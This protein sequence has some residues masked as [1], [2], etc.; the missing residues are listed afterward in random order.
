MPE[1][2]TTDLYV[3]ETV[4]DT[5]A[6]Q[7]LELDFLLPD[8]EPEVFRV[9]KTRVSP[10]VQQVRASGGRLEIS[11]S[12]TVSVLYLG[13]DTHTLHAV[14]QSVPFSKSLDL[15]EGEITARC[16]PRCYHVNARAVSG[17]RLEVR[18]GL[19][20][21]V[22][23]MRQVP[24]PVLTDAAGDGVQLHRKEVTCCGKRVTA[25]K[26]CTLSEDLQLGDAKPAFGSLLDACYQVSITETKL[27]EGK[28]IC[29]GD[30][31]TRL[32]YCPEGG[33]GPES[34]EWSEPVSQI[35]EL[36]GV[37]DSWL[38]NVQAGQVT[39]SFEPVR[40]GDECRTLS[41]EWNL[42]FSACCDKNETCSP[43][44]DGYSCLFQSEPETETLPLW[45]ALSVLSQPVQVAGT[46]PGTGIDSLLALLPAAGETACRSEEGKLILSGA[47]EVTAIVSRGGEIDAVEKALLFEQELQTY[48]GAGMSFFP[49]V[50]LQSIS[51]R[52][53]EGGIEI[54][55]ALAVSG[56]LYENQPVR[57]LRALN[58]DTEKPVEASGAA[59][60]LVYAN[61]GENLWDLAKRC[62]TSLPAILEENGL[63]GETVG[64]RQMLLIPMT[65]E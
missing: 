24:H 42:T 58:L 43:A 30:L 14:R 18:C 8:Y 7:S 29:R 2:K 28:L 19:S 20:L 23:A 56:T 38:C 60:R 10:A 50:S 44:D 16:V 31:T 6:E 52:I 41:A 13:E 51:G 36:P 39:G 46:I 17:R 12:C 49:E 32:L 61:P 48:G 54:Q 47:L 27:V 26:N 25:E 34:M 21:R 3:T 53:T 37:D 5:A 57:T 11:G 22:R 64:K 9:L 55:A 33:G 1:L 35:L 40:N 59:I 45:K 65:T 63:E 62:R 15:P 4:L